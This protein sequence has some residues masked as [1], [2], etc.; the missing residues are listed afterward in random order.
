MLRR[1]PK[2]RRAFVTSASDRPRRLPAPSREERP[3][4]AAVGAA[5][6]RARVS[7][8][9]PR[10]ARVSADRRLLRGRTVGRGLAAGPGG[11]YRLEADRCRAR[12]WMEHVVD[13]VADMLEVPADRAVTKHRGRQ[14]VG[15]ENRRSTS[16]PASRRKTSSRAKAGTASSSTCT[17][18]S[19]PACSS[20]IASRAASS[21]RTPAAGASSTS[22][23]TPAASRFMRPPAARRRKASTC[24]TRIAVGPAEPRAER[25][26]PGRTASS[27]PTC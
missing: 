24:R 10:R 4:H 23:R 11:R 20:I 7:A 18:I 22:S 8:V 26:R 3:P 6:G 16:R 13:A 25:A 12:E 21:A 2:R 19:T 14:R 9:R 27:G 17:A 5:C 15:G 1:G